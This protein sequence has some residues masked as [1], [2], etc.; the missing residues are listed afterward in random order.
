MLSAVCVFLCMSSSLSSVDAQSTRRTGLTAV[1]AG[2]STSDFVSLY[3]ALY[4]A[5]SS[6]PFTVFSAGL[7]PIEFKQNVPVEVKERLD[8]YSLA[9]NDLPE[10]LK[11]ALLWENGYSLG[12]AGS[13]AQI[14]TLCGLSMAEIA[15]SEDEYKVSTCG[16]ESCGTT[17]WSHSPACRSNE[18]LVVAK[19]A[20]TAVD[21][22]SGASMWSSKTL[23]AQPSTS[24]VPNIQIRRHNWTDLEAAQPAHVYAIHTTSQEQTDMCLASS[25]SA[26]VV[27][28]VPYQR[29]DKRWCR[30]T[31][32]DVMTN[33]LEDY[34]QRLQ[35]D[36]TVGIE[37]VK[38]SGPAQPANATKKTQDLNA[39]A[40]L[41]KDAHGVYVSAAYRFDGS[42]SDFTQ[43]FYR[44]YLALGAANEDANS[45]SKLVLQA[46]MPREV[47]QRLTDASLQF[48]DL[49]ALLQR[50]LVWDSGY[51]MDATSSAL[52]AVYVKCGLAM[53]DIA[54][55]EY[56]MSQVVGKSGNSSCTAQSCS[57]RSSNSSDG[58]ESSLYRLS[59]CTDDQVKTKSM[60][61]VAADISTS[62]SN[63]SSPS[64]RLTPMWASGGDDSAT[65]ELSVRRHTWAND[66]KAYIMFSIKA[67]TVTSNTTSEA[68][69]SSSKC[70]DT[71]SMIIPCVSYSPNPAATSTGTDSAFVKGEDWC[72]PRPG[73]LV[74]SWLRQVAKEKQFSLLYLIPI[75]IS[76]ALGVTGLAIYIRRK[77]FKRFELK[78]DGG[79]RGGGVT[80]GHTIASTPDGTFTYGHLSLSQA[81]SCIMVD[82]RLSALSTSSSIESFAAFSSNPVLNTLVNHPSLRLNTIPF[83]QIQFINLL[84][85]KGTRSELWLGSV[86]G[87]HVAVKRLARARKAEYD[88]L[89]EYMSEITLHASLDHPNLVKFIGI[90]WTTLQNLCMVTEYVENG[91]LQ[92]YLK[93]H[94]L[95][96]AWEKAKMRIAMGIVSAICCLHQQQPHVLFGDLKSKNVLLTMELDAKLINA[97]VNPRTRVGQLMADEA[98]GLTTSGK[99]ETPYWTAPEV[100]QGE[101]PSEKADMYA[102][103]VI[104]AELDTHQPPYEG[105]KCMTTGTNL[106]PH[107][108]LHKIV[109]GEL[110][111]TTSPFCPLEIAELIDTCLD[112]DPQRR[113]SASEAMV[114]LTK[115]PIAS[116]GAKTYSF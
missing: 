37:T 22:V 89:E 47:K 98:E 21:T 9:F 106:P 87:E 48:E 103:G 41:A 17:T 66:G 88:E 29:T 36:H 11:R 114:V 56:A 78:T 57:Y 65:P 1:K 82:A 30:P 53:S 102:F 31:L 14:H 63:N 19:C 91:D 72:R 40:A 69:S 27:P 100:L 68:T 111:P 84:S 8:V 86:R 50:A 76:V 109:A 52:T 77:T 71:P 58:N 64:S 97:G 2:A 34:A 107:Q 23:T 61:A 83:D 59:T 81:H 62:N 4:N 16:V 67:A 28:C 116:V 3:Y 92:L 112:T 115:V 93:Q 43:Q 45:I 10:L 94:C 12:D 104:L 42:S 13:I 105:L 110:K 99:E 113:P 35:L 38:A 74:T 7:T 44:R 95:Q 79:A 24:A 70:P 85:E 25:P 75:L 55:S 26:V 39:T 73:P 80:R 18:L 5:S 46:P 90:A 20:T 6:S 33:W 96:L 51:V 108:I 32:S 101:M 54:V 49:P 15:L 60:C